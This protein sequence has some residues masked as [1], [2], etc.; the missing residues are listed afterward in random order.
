MDML[1]KAGSKAVVVKEITGMGGG[2][3]EYYVMD[4]RSVVAMFQVPYTNSP[5]KEWAALSE[6]GKEEV[7]QKGWST[8]GTEEHAIAAALDHVGFGEEDAEFARQEIDKLRVEAVEAFQVM[9][10]DTKVG[11]D[12]SRYNEIRPLVNAIGELNKQL[13]VFDKMDELRGGYAA[14]WGYWKIPE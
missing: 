14:L 13:Q 8:R 1:V 12:D 2:T 3:E 7:R 5:E 10:S 4:S 9:V 6:L 11:S